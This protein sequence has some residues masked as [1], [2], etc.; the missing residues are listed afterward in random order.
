[1][2]NVATNVQRDLN[3]SLLPRVKARMEP[4]YAA[5]L[6]VQRGSGTFNRMKNAMHQHSNVAVKSMFTEST[7]ELLDAVNKMITQLYGMVR[8]VYE[9][10]HKNLSNVYRILWEDQTN[11]MSLISAEERQKIQDC[12]DK[13]L[14][15][16]NDLRQIQN[17]AMDLLGIDREDLELEMVAVDTF[18]DTMAKKIERA[19]QTGDYIDL[20]DSDEEPEIEPQQSSNLAKALAHQIKV[21]A[22]P[23]VAVAA[24]P[25]APVKKTPVKKSQYIGLYDSDDDSTDEWFRSFGRPSGSRGNF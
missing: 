21:K 17:A 19:K 7:K 23:A 1:M 6:A 11:Q 25:G 10:I 13:C 14:P 15:E 12:R 4:G 20:C 5:A 2:Q 16:L 9:T 3:R 8:A 22:E 18:E 24:A